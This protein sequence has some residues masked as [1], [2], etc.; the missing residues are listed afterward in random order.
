MSGHKVVEVV[1][2]LV[3]CLGIEPGITTFIGAGGKTTTLFQVAR[4]LEAKQQRVI[5][6]TTT[7]MYYPTK[8]QIETVLINPTNQLIQQH[9]LYKGSLA[10]GGC[11]KDGKLTAVPLERIEQLKQLAD[12]IL[13]EGDGAKR[14]PMKVPSAHEPVI[15]KETGQVVVVAGLKALG[16]PLETG[17]FRTEKAMAL[18]GVVETHLMTEEDMATLITS[19][20]G[21][22]K[23]I[24]GTSQILLLNQIDAI[25]DSACIKRLVGYIKVRGGSRIV[26][27][28][29]AKG[30]WQKS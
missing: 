6:T 4:E 12:Y 5:I 24:E 7:K 13:I 21:L 11:V 18:L 27:G 3:T 23:G 22:Q 29:V 9:I 1:E 19:P 10:I 30:Q 28:A 25:E 16:Q 26:L 2:D 15:P 17:C 8:D 20:Q 14:Y